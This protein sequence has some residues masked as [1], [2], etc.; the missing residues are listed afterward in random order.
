MTTWKSLILDTEKIYSQI[1]NDI[2]QK[3]AGKDYPVEVKRLQMGK[4][5]AEAAQIFVGKVYFYLVKLISEHSVL[6][7]VKPF[8]KFGFF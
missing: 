3:Y 6:I 1:N 2:C 5:P 8:V 4:K 7:M